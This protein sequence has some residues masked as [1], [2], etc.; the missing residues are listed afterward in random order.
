[1]RKILLL[2]VFILLLTATTGC[3]QTPEEDVVI[4]KDKIDRAHIESV[5]NNVPQEL[6]QPEHLTDS[7]DTKVGEIMLPFTVRVDADI[8][9]PESG[10]YPVY[11]VKK[12]DF[13]DAETAVKII[14]YLFD[15][16]DTY[17][18]GDSFVDD[19]TDHCR[20]TKA[21]I[22]M[23]QDALSEVL[24]RV[25][26][27]GVSFDLLDGSVPALG[28]AVGLVGSPENIGDDPRRSQ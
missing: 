8:T 14:E 18:A 12:A 10:V 20:L 28:N 7:F 23:H 9:V 4:G 2:L 26:A 3:V 19:V 11:S 24:K 5:P 6:G 22:R 27:V 21:M 15:G 25:P 17:D 16:C 13:F 1:M